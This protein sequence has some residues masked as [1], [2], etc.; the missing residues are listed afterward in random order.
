MEKSFEVSFASLSS[1]GNSIVDSAQNN[2]PASV[3]RII[4]VRTAQWI[5][6]A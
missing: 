4:L 6:G 1:S 3:A 2:I 5:R